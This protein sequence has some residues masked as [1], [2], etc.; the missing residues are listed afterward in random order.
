MPLAGGN[1]QNRTNPLVL[2]NLSIRRQARP[3]GLAATID[4]FNM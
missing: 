1:R 2:I 3:G 4:A